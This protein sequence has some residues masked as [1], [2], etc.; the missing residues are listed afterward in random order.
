[1]R[2]NFARLIS[3]GCT[4]LFP[5]L[6]TET[7][8]SPVGGCG[9]VHR[10]NRNKR[11]TLPL[12]GCDCSCGQRLLHRAMPA[13]P[14]TL[15]SGSGGCGAHVAAQEWERALS[16]WA[17]GC[18]QTDALC[19][20]AL[21]H[22]TCPDGRF[23]Q[24]GSPTP[25]CCAALQ[26]SASRPTPGAATCSCASGGAS[27]EYRARWCR[28]P[29]MCRA[30]SQV[31]GG[32]CGVA[33]CALL[34]AVASEADIQPPRCDGA[35]PCGGD[36]KGRRGELKLR[37]CPGAHPPCATAV[38]RTAPQLVPAARRPAGRCRTR[39]P[40]RAPPARRRPAQPRPRRLR[41]R[42]TTRC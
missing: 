25:S 7:A 18:K 24:L 1:M 26:H 12:R 14:R 22:L 32:S 4:V 40:L 2:T 36:R 16:A 8:S 27:S 10:N 31:G 3:G 35:S 20:L 41:S 19:V 23:A 11:S 34:P 29:R 42:G 5:H 6:P 9:L 30:R 13:P 21:P 39:A 37:R 38:L 17:A 15:Q 28:S 33:S